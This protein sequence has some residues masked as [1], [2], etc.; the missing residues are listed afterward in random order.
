MSEYLDTKEYNTWDESI[1]GIGSDQDGG[2]NVMS[3]RQVM[4]DMYGFCNKQV[5]IMNPLTSGFT[6]KNEFVLSTYIN[7][8]N[9]N[10]LTCNGSGVARCNAGTVSAYWV[11]YFDFDN[12][13]RMCEADYSVFA[14]P[15]QNV[16]MDCITG[17]DS[18]C[19]DACNAGCYNKCDRWNNACGGCTSCNAR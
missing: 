2:I 15:Q 4:D 17:C 10:G 19:F 5:A 7:D 12:Y 1:T 11:E 18:G 8:I 3:G 13:Q 16:Y 14:R 6:Y 9:T